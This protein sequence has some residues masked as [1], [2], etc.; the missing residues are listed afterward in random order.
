MAINNKLRKENI[1][2]SSEDRIRNRDNKG[3]YWAEGHSFSCTCEGYV[4]PAI[5]LLN[6]S[7]RF[8]RYVS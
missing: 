4:I 1:N 8:N 3:R 6:D 7:W 5:T 2:S